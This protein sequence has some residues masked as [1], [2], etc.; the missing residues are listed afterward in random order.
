MKKLKVLLIIIAV[1]ETIAVISLP[2][3]L[4]SSEYDY[5]LIKE[6]DNIILTS[7][8]HQADYIV[9]DRK[10]INTERNQVIFPTDELWYSFKVFN[11]KNYPTNI[12]YELQFFKY[13]T[14]IGSPY[15]GSE[16][17]E[18]KSNKTPIFKKIYL[19]STGSYDI[20]FNI[21]FTNYTSGDEYYDSS[22]GFEDI[23]ILSR[24]EQL[25]IEQ[26][27]N[28][29]RGVWISAFIGGGTVAALVL[30][31]IFSKK[32]VDKLDTQNQ[33]AKDQIGL[34]KKQ[35]ENL[36]EQN[37]FQNRPWISIISER[38]FNINGSQFEIIFQNYGKSVAHDVKTTVY[39][40]KGV[41]TKGEII[42]HGT[43]YPEFDISPNEIF[44]HFEPISSSLVSDVKNTDDVCIG[45][46]MEYYFENTKKGTS[47][48][49][50]N[51][52]TSHNQTIF[53]IKKLT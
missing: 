42:K 50:V 36:K 39:V 5:G 16:Q 40:K 21:I 51:W 24:S 53:K 27:E 45:I 2:F 30:S 12:D 52:V 25:Q 11:Y 4:S 41:I 28:F 18:P 13:N 34:L 15:F 32:E 47:L 14:P 6:F 29:L 35:N 22:K 19:N 8:D 7:N 17:L 3:Y 26:N 31:V 10:L 1:I 49:V 33:H 9:T 37:S 43:T 38:A 46:L 20:K 44:S 23:E 48:L